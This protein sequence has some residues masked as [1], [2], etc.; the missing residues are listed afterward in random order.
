M[1]TS[2]SRD[3]SVK[4]STGNDDTMNKNTSRRPRPKTSTGENAAITH[5]TG[6]LFDLKREEEAQE[7]IA[8]KQEAA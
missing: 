2:T 5:F 8:A 1:K 6:R 7:E 4:H 3:S